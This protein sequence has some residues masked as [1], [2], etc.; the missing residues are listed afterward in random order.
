MRYSNREGEVK[1]ERLILTFGKKVF[2]YVGNYVYFCALKYT[3]YSSFQEY[4]I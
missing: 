2:G 4:S 1:W 3:E